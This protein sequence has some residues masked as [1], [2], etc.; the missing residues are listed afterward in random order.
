MKKTSLILSG[1]LL[2]VALLFSSCGGN[3]SD[4]PK[5]E[6]TKV[7]A[8]VYTLNTPD[9]YQGPEFAVE[10]DAKEFILEVAEVPEGFQLVVKSD[11]VEKVESWGNAYYCTYSQIEDVK[12][13]VDLAKELA[14]LKAKSSEVTKVV[15]VTVQNNKGA[16]NS[17]KIKSVSVKG[18]DD[19]VSVKE[20][21]TPASWESWT[22]E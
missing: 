12:V 9:N 22:I 18:A 20:F 14:D 17:C 4:E 8:K 21:P 5:K 19:K 2:A 11:A 6:E 16:A 15:S 7:D 10:A 1:A 13:V 3:G